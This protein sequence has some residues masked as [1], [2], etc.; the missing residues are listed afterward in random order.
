MVRP[1][2]TG[3]PGF[4]FWP[5]TLLIALTLAGLIL[6]G[7]SCDGGGRVARSPNLII[8]LVDTL[9]ADHLH[10]EGYARETSPQIDAL[11]ARSIVFEN[12]YSTAS[13][14]GPA[15]ASLFTG[16]FPRSHGVLNPLTEWD[17]KG[18]LGAEQ[19][20]LAEILK[21]AGYGCFGFITNPNVT[22][23][24]GFGQGFDVYQPVRGGCDD[25]N[26]EA[27]AALDF[28]AR[29]P[30]FLYLH[31]MEPHSPYQAP[32]EYED[33]YANPGYRGPFTGEHEQL[34]QIVAGQLVARPQ[35]V[36]QLKALYDQEIR[37]FDDHLAELL[38]G[39]KERGF[40][41]N[42]I[43]LFLSDHGEEFLDHGS[44]LH[45]YTLYEEQLRVPFFIH[46]GRRPD[47]GAITAI[48]RHVDLLPTLLDLLEIPD[49]GLH[50]GRSLLPLMEGDAEGV[51][52][53]GNPPVFAEA[54]LRAVKTVRRRSLLLDGWKIIETELPAPRRELYH[55]AE[56]PLER[57]DLSASRP[58][59]LL[60]M[61]E[62]MRALVESMPRAR[63]QSVRLREK[64]IEALR[65]LGYLK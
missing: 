42:S 43:L 8:I 27:L 65:S 64:E 47:P 26:R 44:A 20:T 22:S 17:A 52:D 62:K 32:A 46:D 48:S 45:G 29:E 33:L 50:Q 53:D 10:Y 6:T 3:N 14:T 57:T 36:A 4:R 34:D 7:V 11:A 49:E 19:T 39:L 54:S 15:V 1:P 35:D 13:R 12:H 40:Y 61:S 2:S 5:S 55:L 51:G 16:L 56:D 23:R 31:Y 41:E 25:V 21:E 24:F 38:A 9:R 60:R 30:F 28:R 58:K 37:C 59:M 18:I 63:S